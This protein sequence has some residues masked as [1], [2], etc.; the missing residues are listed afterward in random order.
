MKSYTLVDVKYYRGHKIVCLMIFEDMYQ[1]L[2]R[3]I[4]APMNT[5]VSTTKLNIA[6]QTG[7][8]G[9]GG[10]VAQSVERATPCEEVPGSIPTVAARSLLVGSVSV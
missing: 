10:G 9:G 3:I 4:A 5:N 8:G 7:G 6:T 1:Y 2:W